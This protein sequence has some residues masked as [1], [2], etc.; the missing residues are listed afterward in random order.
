MACHNCL[1]LP[2]KSSCNAERLTEFI[3]LIN[4]SYIPEMNAIVPPETPGTTSAA[5]HGSSF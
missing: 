1:N 5:P 4:S 2:F 3:V